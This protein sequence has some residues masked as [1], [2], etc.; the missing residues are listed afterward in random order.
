MANKIFQTIVKYMDVD[1]ISGFEEPVVKKFKEETKKF[2]LNYTRDGLG[3]IIANFPIAKGPKVVLVGHLDEVG[4]LVL[5]ILDNG[6]IQLSPIGGIWSQVAVGSKVEVTSSTNK[7]FMGIIGHTSVHILAIEK[8]N[9]ALKISDLFA[10]FGF[11]SKAD[12][13]ANGIESG[14]PICFKAEAFL[15]HNNL[16][17]G[18]A[19]DNRV[20]L[21]V[22]ELLIE[23]MSKMKLVNNPYFAAS[24]QEEVGCR[25]AKTIAQAIDADIMIAIDVCAAHD[26]TGAIKGA[27]KIGSGVCIALKDGYNLISPKLVEYVVNLAK[28]HKIPYTK[29]VSQGGGTDASE[30]QYSNKGALTLILSISQR[31]LHA[32]YGVASLDDLNHLV[33]LLVEFLKAFDAKTL[34]E[35]KF[36]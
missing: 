19:V 20:S 21:A 26:T 4:F 8:R 12:A 24:V 2:N 17:S 22:L 25:G 29:F 9:Q 34:A 10:D 7:K 15:M 11:S 36:K 16:V 31:Y 35:L 27:T 30:L 1:G 6:Q 33:N 28:K 23:K 18:K 32:S 13:I 3:S 14:N 5:D